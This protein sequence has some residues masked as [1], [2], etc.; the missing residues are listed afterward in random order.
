MTKM[1]GN[2]TVIITGPRQAGVRD[3]P[4]GEPGAGEVLVQTLCSGISAGTELN[5]Y[6]GVAPQWRRRQDRESH[7]FVAG[8]PE[9]TYPLVYGYANIGVVRAAGPA[10]SE[11]LIGETV[12]S[13]RPHRAWN[14]VGEADLIRLPP[15]PDVRRGVFLANLTTALN[16]VLDAHPNLGDVVVVSGLGVIGL[17]VTRLLSRAGAGLVIG[18]D[19]IEMRRALAAEAGA[20]LVL[21]PSAD[22]PEIVLEQTEGRGAD[23]VIDASGAAPAL[24]AAIRSVGVDG[25][26][27]AL[28]WYGDAIEALEL[29]A[30]FHHNRVRIR[31]S[32]G[33]HISPDLGR[34]WS[35]ERRNALSLKLL[36]E[37]PLERYITHE[38][39]P[40]DASEAYSRLDR[41]EPDVLQ[42]V[43]TFAER[44]DGWPPHSR[45]AAGE[46][47]HA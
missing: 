26:V 30:E 27:I 44:G 37:L 43:F 34:Q 2:P 5:V 15:L 35:L 4:I 31:S 9:W 17:L 19:Q 1:A 21:E 46:H 14:V 24:G 3:E 38:F 22:L 16:G 29:G 20:G 12:F 33:D 25:L 40:E 47:E 32:Q 28:S 7:L 13:Y 11:Q 10:V 42:C 23:I 36:A 8:D 45:G 39:A 6:R 41:R 18:V